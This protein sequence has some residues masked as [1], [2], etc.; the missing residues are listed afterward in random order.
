MKHIFPWNH[1]R[2]KD[3]TRLK[4]MLNLSMVTW[5]NFFF[6][7]YPLVCIFTEFLNF[8]ICRKFLDPHSFA[9]K[10]GHF[11]E[12]WNLVTLIKGFTNCT[13]AAWPSHMRCRPDSCIVLRFGWHFSP[14]ELLK[15]KKNSCDVSVAVLSSWQKVHFVPYS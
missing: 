4:W 3:L 9:L 1:F 6:L 7:D 10:R 12:M 15:Y 5:F 2:N 11:G 14:A 8:Q 13:D